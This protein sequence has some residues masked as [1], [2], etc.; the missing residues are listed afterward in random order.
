MTSTYRPP[1]FFFAAPLTRGPTAPSKSSILLA[2][3]MLVVGL[4]DGPLAAEVLLPLRVMAG[5]APGVNLS[6]APAPPG[7]PPAAGAEVKLAA[8]GGP[9]GGALAL[10]SS[11][12][13]PP[14][15]GGGGVDLALAL[16]P[17]G[18][19][20]GGGVAV[21]LAWSSADAFLFTQRFCS[22]S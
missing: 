10:P 20:G 12:P 9:P 18:P 8:L 4:L 1:F 16:P 13:A 19:R 2:L 15:W 14:E 3:L 11:P 5:G 6:P 7:G 22:G 17:G 21:F